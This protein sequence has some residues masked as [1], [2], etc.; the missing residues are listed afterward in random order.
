[1]KRLLVYCYF[2]PEESE[3]LGGVQQIVGPLLDTL[4]AREGWTV[5][6]VHRETCTTSGHYHIPDEDVD[7][8]ANT[9]NPNT[10][11]DA[12]GSFRS[13]AAD[14]D[15]VLSIDK[16]LPAPVSTPCVLMS[17]TLGYEMQATAIRSNLWSQIIVPTTYHKECVD[18]VNM[19]ATVS[20]VHYGLPLH[21]LESAR[22]I[23][24]ASW[25]DRP[26]TLLL[27]HRPDPR[28]GHREAIQ[29]LS[30]AMPNANHIELEI[31]WFNEQD[32]TMAY[33]SELESLASELGVEDNLSFIPWMSG[34]AKWDAI[35]QSSGVLALG[36]F[37]ETFG[38]AIVE[39]VLSGRPVVSRPQPASREVVGETSLLQELADPTE[40]FQALTE[41]YTNRSLA[42]EQSTRRRLEQALSLDW[43]ASSYDTL[44]T[45]ELTDGT[46]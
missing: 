10:A 22:S 33:R 38:L 45:E 20:V 29:G 46:D 28:K 43:M 1:M 16:I 5:S 42:E 39:A 37:K 25:T 14:H 44:L 9:I 41:Y 12:A 3:K 6:V 32:S 15:L 8:R 13:L 18:Q 30:N 35:E 21:H 11:V 7:V 26:L 4:E 23:E 24:P 2:C 34:A 19:D 31:T 27:P 17:N 40:W 36:E